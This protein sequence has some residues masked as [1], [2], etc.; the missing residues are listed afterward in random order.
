[1]R[2]CGRENKWEI[3]LHLPLERKKIERNTRCWGRQHKKLQNLH[4]FS[5]NQDT[6]LLWSAHGKCRKNYLLSHLKLLSKLF[7]GKFQ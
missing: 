7:H 6:S 3:R 1:M 4:I 2:R 5:N